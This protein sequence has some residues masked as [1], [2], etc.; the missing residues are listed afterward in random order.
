MKNILRICLAGI[1]VML[2]LGGTLVSGAVKRNV[3]SPGTSFPSNQLYGATILYP[4]DDAHVIE[5][6][7]D[8]NTGLTE[9]LAI[10]N[11]GSGD[12][13]ASQPVIK[14]DVTSISPSAIVVSAILN[15]YYYQYSDNNPGGRPL[16]VYRLE[17]DW[18]EETITWN[19]KPTSSSTLSSSG[20]VPNSVGA[21]MSFDVTR[22]VRNFTTGALNNY[23]WIIKDEQYWGGA[24]IPTAECSAKEHS[25]GKKP[26]LN[27]TAVDLKKSFLLGKITN[28]QTEGD[29]YTFD[30]VRLRCI[31]FS[32]FAVEK[33]V[34]GEKI[35]VSKQKIG[36]LETG[37]ALGF[38]SY[39]TL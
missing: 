29:F 21:W 37:F 39:A 32:P 3:S 6:H 17:G 25:N 19:N 31:Q 38:F 12:N 36:L 35:Y 34:S 10:R 24:N 22:D 15:I 4:T 18:N 33:Y 9:N 5:N 16:S 13:W 23:G 1:I 20:S 8:V 27:V 2:L 26:Y 14:F 11:G 28:L 30:A 7:P